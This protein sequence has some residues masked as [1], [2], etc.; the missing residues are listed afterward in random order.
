M[1]NN[2]GQE[3]TNNYMFLLILFNPKEENGSRG[4]NNFP[5]G[6][7]DGKIPQSG[8]IGIFFI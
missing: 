3:R 8:S 5:F 6:K 7:E 4:G 2:T 1:P